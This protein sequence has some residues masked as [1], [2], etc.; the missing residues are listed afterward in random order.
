ML[1]KLFDFFYLIIN[2]IQGY[3][4]DTAASWT[5]TATAVNVL[6]Y[7]QTHSNH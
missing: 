6:L 3:E 7:Q 4:K 2:W 5:C 1:Y